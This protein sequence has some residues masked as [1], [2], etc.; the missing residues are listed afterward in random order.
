M[1][2]TFF[3]LFIAFVI[4]PQVVFSQS[5]SEQR[6][7]VGIAPLSLILPSGKVGLHAEWAYGANKSLSLTVGVPRSTRPPGWVL[8]SVSIAENGSV[9]TNEFYNF[10]IMIENRFYFSQEAP[11]GFYLAPYLRYNKMWLDRIT[12]N[13]EKTGATTMRGTLY[14]IGVGGAV[15]WQIPLGEHFTLDATFAAIDLK[16]MRGNVS[17]SSTDTNN[18]IYELRDEVQAVVED[19]P[20]V[21]KKLSA[22]IDGEQIKVRTPGVVLPAYRFS[23]TVNYLF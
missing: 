2:S 20:I 5:F 16:W 21:G 22:Q 6:F 1:K 18:D 19:I 4:V 14:G 12:E 8:N 10:G 3:A 7:S 15:G 11:Y 17:Y 23:L 13:P 9:T